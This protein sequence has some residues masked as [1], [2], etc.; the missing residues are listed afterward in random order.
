[1]IKNVCAPPVSGTLQERTVVRKWKSNREGAI[2]K[3]ALA[4]ERKRALDERSERGVR[5][6]DDSAVIAQKRMASHTWK[7]QVTCVDEG[8]QVLAVG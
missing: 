8:R 2:G 5:D 1:M 3:R 6:L 4:K 7:R